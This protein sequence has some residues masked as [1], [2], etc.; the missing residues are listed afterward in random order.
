[1]ITLA[2]VNNVYI[3][4]LQFHEYFEYFLCKLGHSRANY[5]G[6]RGRG[7]NESAESPR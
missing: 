6:M 4:V 5:L 7:G 2:I 3:G 1:M